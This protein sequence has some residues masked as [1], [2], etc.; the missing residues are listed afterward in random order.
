[1]IYSG[2]ITGT[3]GTTA[4]GGAG[5][6]IYDGPD[7]FGVNTNANMTFAKLVVNGGSYRN[8]NGGGAVDQTFGATPTILTPDAIM[9]NNGGAKK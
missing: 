5:T 6:L 8:R 9:L 1:V 7:Q 4:N 2:T 3:G